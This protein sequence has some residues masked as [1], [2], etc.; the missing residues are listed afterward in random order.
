MRIKKLKKDRAC[1]E[2]FFAR[3]A[4]W[5]SHNKLFL[6]GFEK[7]HPQNNR[8]QNQINKKPSHHRLL[9]HL[10]LLLAMPFR[11]MK[12]VIL[13]EKNKNFSL[14]N[15]KIICF[16]S[17]SE[18][19]W[20]KTYQKILKLSPKFGAFPQSVFSGSSKLSSTWP[21]IYIANIE[22]EKHTSLPY[23]FSAGLK[24]LDS[25]CPEQPFEEKSFTKTFFL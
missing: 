13:E 1:R 7:N 25:T 11:K 4:E 5:N 21:E 18:C 22:L 17:L 10:R 24:N 2:S 3:N 12:S 19:K 8:T 23:N 6:I 14:R 9:F 16:L 15:S 20:K